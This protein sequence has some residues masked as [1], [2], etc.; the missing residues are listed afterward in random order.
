MSNLESRSN[1]SDKWK[2]LYTLKQ[3]ISILDNAISRDVGNGDL[4]AIVVLLM[5]QTGIRVGGNGSIRGRLVKDATYG[6]T[7]LRAKHVR[8][9]PQNSLIIDFVGKKGVR[10]HHVI[11]DPLL[12]ESLRLI[13]NGRS[14]NDPLFTGVSKKTTMEYMRRVLGL[15]D[16]KNHDLRTLVANDIAISTVK[17]LP[18][19]NTEK[20]YRKLRNSVG[21]V[22]ADTLGNGRYHAL[23][24]YIDP[25][26]FDRWKQSGWTP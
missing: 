22:V 19:P 11:R 3:N 26:V 20:E 5:R 7:T 21:E 9:T 13:T 8:I 1:S 15:V 2:R 24:S 12:V 23:N 25:T 6:A 17:S 16:I 14:G 10:H 4:N 18:Y